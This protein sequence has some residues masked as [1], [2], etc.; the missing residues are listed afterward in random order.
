MS[1][2]LTINMTVDHENQ[3]VDTSD[4]PEV[5]DDENYHYNYDNHQNQYDK[6]NDC[7]SNLP[8]IDSYI[9]TVCPG[10]PI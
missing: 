4:K 6:K 3:L 10:P 1:M 2:I 7:G 9:S 8:N 5:L